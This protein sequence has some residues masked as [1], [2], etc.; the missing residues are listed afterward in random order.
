MADQ[1]NFAPTDLTP[2]VNK[3]TE[4]ISAIQTL[5]GVGEGIKQK[6]E[7]DNELDKH[8]HNEHTHEDKTKK[9]S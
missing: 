4:L 5:Q 7:E 2:V 1:C 6:Q 9:R 3:L 8:A